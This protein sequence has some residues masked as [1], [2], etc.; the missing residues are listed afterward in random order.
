MPHETET[1]CCWEVCRGYVA[2]LMRPVCPIMLRRHLR[3]AMRLKTP[4]RI[5]NSQVLIHRQPTA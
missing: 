3:H 2:V 1:L 4:H 5:V